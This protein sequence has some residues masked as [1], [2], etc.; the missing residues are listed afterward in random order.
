MLLAVLSG[1]IWACLAPW[2]HRV[3]GP[4]SHWLLAA[5]P[6]ALFAFFLTLLPAAG[7]GEPAAALLEWVPSLGVTLSFRA[8]GLALLFALLISGIGVLV[9]LYS[10]GYLHGHPMLGRW[11]LFLFAFMASML[12]VVLSDNVYLLFVF[13]ELTSVT[14]Y[15]LIGFNHDEEK[16]RAAAL[17][18][19]LVTGAGG[20]A[21]LAGLV[22][23]ARAGG[24]AE[25]SVLAGRGDL[26][27]GHGLYPAIL[28]LV[29]LGAFTKSAQFPFHFWLP[30]AMAAP[31]PASAYLH[32]STMVKAG[33]Y[34]LA[35]MHPALGGTPSWQF[36][37]TAAGAATMLLGA[38]MAFHQT[39]LKR[40]LAYS[41]VSALGVITL[42]LGL[43]GAA[44]VTAAMA[45]LFAHALY[46]AALF[47]VAGAVDHGTGERDVERLG[48]LRRAMPLTAAGAAVAGLSMAG[49]PPLFGFTA[50]EL[51]YETLLHAPGIAPGNANLLIG[52]LLPAAVLSAAFFLVVA[53]SVAFKPFYGAPAH[54][55]HHPHEAPPA[56]WLGPALLGV[57]S[58][59]FGLFPGFIG[60]VLLGHAADA[61]LGAP[62][63]AHLALWHGLTP[64]LGLS[65]L[66]LAA[67]LLLYRF[68]TPL[69]A[70]S[71]PLL[72]A[73][74][75]GP[76]RG[77]D[78]ALAGMVRFA[79]AQTRALQNG[80]LRNY[81]LVIFLTLLALVVPVLVMHTQMLN[82]M[83]LRKA[84]E[85]LLN[86]RHY[87]LG[88]AVLMV[89]SIAAVVHS[90]TRLAAVAALGVV[91]YGVALIF[92]LFGAPDLAM[93]QF[94]IET[95]TV[96]LLV[97]TFYHLPAFAVYAPRAVLLR[98]LAVAVAVGVT[99]AVLVLIA[100]DSG[101]YPNIAHYFE[102]NSYT[103][104][105]GRNVVNVILVDFR[106]LDT[107]GEITVLAVAAVG[108]WSLLS[109]R[110]RRG[111]GQ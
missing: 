72:R 63:H 62:A 93:T 35:R 10:G 107:L 111:D 20:L 25:I 46:K 92:I 87:E 8:D 97:L 57:C 100:A 51:L 48:G 98:D 73:A 88:L 36:W 22:L 50:K 89:V 105:H 74:R 38:W 15:L 85:S 80:Y 83:F 14:S 19:L 49:L 94:V 23:L 28:A 59:L 104:G 40:L 76:E 108:A 82:E 42:L 1:F 34:L 95:L 11:Y 29:L 18:A 37:V 91:G 6:A 99:M 86:L 101:Q 54:T 68:R 5:L 52:L 66:T 33:V 61:A 106:G 64:A 102:E 45:F 96:I 47:L 71:A 78:A 7:R 103:L 43:G 75:F 31:T 53:L 109:M 12:G 55:P 2:I 26:L 60:H 110:P 39:I 41:T 21:L 16:S 77:Y 9:T 69:R 65:V 24:S 84:A 27:R 4:R 30:N 13:W 81:L 32:S 3:A 79:H 70:A 17:Q 44:A 67:G 58:I 56:M 90:K